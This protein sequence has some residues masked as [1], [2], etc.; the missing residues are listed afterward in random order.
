MEP[1]TVIEPH[2]VIEPHIGVRGFGFGG[3]ALSEIYA[4]L[5]PRD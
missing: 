5:R 2:M 1:H 4:T 3:G